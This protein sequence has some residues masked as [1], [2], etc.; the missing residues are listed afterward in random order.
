ML[1]ENVSYGNRRDTPIIHVTEHPEKTEQTSFWSAQCS[2]ALQYL[3]L[4]IL[5]SLNP[6]LTSMRVKHVASKVVNGHPI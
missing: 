5:Q 1:T 3:R 4:I 2:N 6:L